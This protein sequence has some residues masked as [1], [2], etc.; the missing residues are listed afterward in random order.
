MEMFSALKKKAPNA[1]IC[2][3]AWK[4]MA[5]KNRT[6]DYLDNMTM[7]HRENVIKLAIMQERRQRPPDPSNGE[8][9]HNAAAPKSASEVRS[10]L[11]LAN[12]SP[13][14]I[15]EFATITQPLRELTKKRYTVC[16]TC[17][18]RE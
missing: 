7:E 3:L 17:I 13:R 8:A 18:F 6:V 14:F 2:F 4:M 15:T 11:C 10:L 9:I 5:V 1:T 16:I 12:F